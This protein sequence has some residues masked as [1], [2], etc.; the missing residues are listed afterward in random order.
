MKSVIIM[1]L[2]LNSMN[3]FAEWTSIGKNED[4]GATIYAETQTIRKKGNKVKIWSLYDYNKVQVADNTPY[5]SSREIDEFDCSDATYQSLEISAFSENMGK[6]KVVS[7]Y[8]I[9]SNIHEIPP[10]SVI[11]GLFKVACGKRK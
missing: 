4:A 10:H 8:S 1:F 11:E 7:L 9:K 5:I 2:L 3:V 6:G